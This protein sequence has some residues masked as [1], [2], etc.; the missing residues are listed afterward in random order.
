MASMPEKKV[1]SESDVALFRKSPGYS[2][3]TTYLEKLCLSVKGVIVIPVSENPGVVSLIA[4]LNRIRQ[5]V[6]ETEPIDQPMRFGNKAFRHVHEWLISQSESLLSES[7]VNDTFI[8]QE[9]TPYMLDSFGN[10]VRID[11][12]TGHEA[13]FLMLL[14]ILIE[15]GKLPMSSCVVLVVLKEYFHLVRYIT[16]KY[17]M[18]PAGSHGVWGLDDYHHLPFLFGA[19]QLIGHESD[20]CR[21]REMLNVCQSISDRSLYAECIQFIRSTKCKHAMFNEVA[22]L[23]HDFSRMD[24]W[25][26]VCYGLMQLYNTEV[27]GKRPIVQ[28][29]YFGQTMRWSN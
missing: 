25:S 10:P 1:K 23:L 18:E 12:G 27:L 7:C 16:T 24:N 14:I 8:I 5:F 3:I 6:D 29:F 20:I 17:V 13:A 19:A 28:H 26:L 11:Y 9:L 2:L 22:P 15:R 21:P 4:L